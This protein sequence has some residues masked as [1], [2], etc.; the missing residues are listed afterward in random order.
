MKKV[1][2]LSESELVNLVKKIIKEQ[3]DG[4]PP[5]QQKQSSSSLG[6]ALSPAINIKIVLPTKKGDETYLVSFNRMKKV[7]DGC[8]FQ[9][10]FRGDQKV[11]TFHYMCDGSLFWK[12]GML[13]Q[14]TEVEISA[15]ANR[16]LTKAC[17]CQLYA[18]NQG[19][20]TGTQAQMAESKR[21]K[22]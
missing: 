19:A 17:G 16:L 4:P 21:T 10:S 13:S 3:E 18:S 7:K 5:A 12:Q 2:R 8:E 20:Q 9:G 22:K 1:L 14:N 6:D 15:D 11:H